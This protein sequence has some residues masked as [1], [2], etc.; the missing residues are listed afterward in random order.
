MFYKINTHRFKEAFKIK[1]NKIDAIPILEESN[2]SFDKFYK[3]RKQIFDS[4]NEL[5]KSKL[6]SVKNLDMKQHLNLTNEKGDDITDTIVGNYTNFVKV[7]AMFVENE[8]TKKKFKMMLFSSDIFTR[9]RGVVKQRKFTLTDL[10]ELFDLNYSTMKDFV[11]NNLAD[12]KE[13]F[14]IL[15]K[16]KLKKRLVVGFNY[17]QY[18]EALKEYTEKEIDDIDDI[19]F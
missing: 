15:K 1:Y 13:Y 6:K 5:E 12:Y 10:N 3:H 8:M 18:K 9:C 17:D 19:D 16:D 2:A 14:L 7:P 11:K 4:L